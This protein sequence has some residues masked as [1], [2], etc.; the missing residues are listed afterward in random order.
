[1]KKRVFRAIGVVIVPIILYLIMRFLWLSSR[2]RFHF[3]TPVDRHQHIC[4]CWHSELLM[5]PQ[6]YR[7]VHPCSPSSAIISQHFDGEIIAKVLGYLH[8]KALR[9]SSRKGAKGVLLQAFRKVKEGS[10][11]LI[12]PDG[13]R[14]PRY[15]MS[16]GA[17]GLALKVNKPIFIM[18]YKAK[19]FWQLKS[20]DRFIIPKP[21]TKID[22]YLQ[23]ISLEGME[24]EEAKQYLQSKMLENAIS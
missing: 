21:F 14:G 12:T 18:N 23:S 7:K 15:S 8:I 2:K 3:I 6:A 17:I 9:G 22:F 24:L 10:E 1:M 20:W 4:V 19:S 16:D 11:V 5:A 13:P